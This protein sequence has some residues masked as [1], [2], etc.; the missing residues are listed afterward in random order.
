[1]GKRWRS[2][3][4][5]VV[6]DTAPEQV[7]NALSEADVT[8]NGAQILDPVTF[9]VQVPYGDLGRAECL[10][11]ERGSSVRVRKAF[12]LRPRLRKLGKRRGLLT[13]ALICAVLLGVSNLFVWRI[14]VQGNEQVPT[15][16]VLRAMTQ[17]GAGIG[18][19]WPGFDSEQLRT[20]LL[21]QLEQVQ[22]VGVNYRSGVVQV[23]VREARE[24][25]ELVDND[26]PVHLQAR[27]AG[28]I[29][30]ISA[31][32]GQ[33]MVAVGDTVER[34]D[35]LISGAVPSTLGTTR[36]VHALGTVEARTW[37]SITARQPAMVR[38]KQYTG[39]KS[40][41][42]SLI[43]G[44]KRLNFYRDSSIF[45][46]SCDKIIKDYHLCAGG[47]FALPVR[48][49]V[50]ACVYR[51]ERERT[52]DQQAQETLATEALM[53]QL[54]RQCGETGTVVTT[55]FASAHRPQGTT[56]TL[57]AECVEEIGEEAAISPEELRQIQMDNTLGDETTND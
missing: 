28:V 2:G 15:G 22:W 8:M 51:T 19:F 49:V 1:M 23:L 48:V 9:Y 32:Q 21:L 39:Q 12:G 43:L 45:G 44:T 38:E 30:A 50:Q 56:M 47:V 29:S 18:S 53:K 54:K 33:P 20:D 4:E 16:A 25:P 37:R 26:S 3:W 40:L 17:A 36:T 46:D 7:L 5:L 31:K 34:G 41:K 13:A 24:P 42:I 57:L 11:R 55:E 6:R 35:R 14:E 10:F 52:L 27:C